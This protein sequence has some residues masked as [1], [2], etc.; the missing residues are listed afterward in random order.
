M[1]NN[2][3]LSGSSPIMKT[4]RG[5]RGSILVFLIVLMVI[6]TALGVGMVSMFGSSILGVFASNSVRRAGYLVESGLRYTISEVRNA[7]AT[8]STPEAALTNV[9]D[10]SVN[11]K[12]FNVFPGVA[13]YRV[14]VYPYWSKTPAGTGVAT[15]VINNATV[16][17]S[18]FPP[19]LPGMPGTSYAIPGVGVG[20]V[21]RLQVGPNN[22]VGISSAPGAT[23]GSK[24][25]T[26]NLASAVTIPSGALAYANLAFP[27]TNTS[28][29]ITKGSAATPLLL[30][31]NAVSAIPQKNGLFIDDTS[32]RWY[33]YQT[34][35]LD[36]SAVPPTVKL[37]NINWGTTSC[38]TTC[39]LACPTACPTATFNPAGI[40]DYYLVF[41]QAARLDATGDVAGGYIQ[42]QK[43][44]DS[45]V[46]LFGL[47][48]TGTMPGPN[49][50]PSSLSA[51][52]SGFTGNLDALDLT[53]S[54]NRVVVQGYI[55]TGGT[56]SYWA[57]FQ[58]LGEAGY[59]FPDPE[60]TS[61]DIGWHVAPIANDISNDLRY[62][63][64]QYHN[65]S[66]DVQIK[67]GWD[68]H[69]DSGGSGLA[70]R[71]HE[72]PLFPGVV[73]PAGDDPYRYYQGYG[74]TF[75]LYKNDSD[76]S[77]DLIP[78]TIKPGGGSLKKKL[79]LVLW[80]QKVNAGGVPR[81]DW[82][83]YAE[84]GDPD[85]THD[86]TTERHPHPDPDQ[87]VTGYQGWPDGRLNDNA[88][89][90]VRVVDKFVT[91]TEG[92]T[93]RYNDIKVFYGDASPNPTFEHDSRTK[94]AVATNK[95]RARYYP[96]WLE[97]G[98]PG[99]Y[100]P[101]INPQWPTNWFDPSGTIAHW[102]NN[103][104]PTG[105]E[106][107]AYDY[108]SLTSSDPTGP[109]DTV[110][111]VKNPSPRTGFESPVNLLPDHCTIRTKD[112]VLDSFPS[113]R[114]EI[115]LVGMGDITGANYTVAFDDF[116][117]QM[118]GGL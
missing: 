83:A 76:G 49:Q 103:P 80:E 57:A 66:Y 67:N 20:G 47:S 85:A 24:A 25:V 97:A 115:G 99:Q 38:G 31:I 11:G 61:R 87:K 101:V 50:I 107:S 13:R 10:G 37:E 106:T 98:N 42:T 113:G 68:L 48:S 8:G 109:Y 55:A 30:N 14:R 60:Q 5:Q 54:G 81:K 94:D 70:F 16:P 56:H 12:W 116:Y 52:E 43:G 105:T 34:A 53:K 91:T 112:F 108:F 32:G 40:S 102:Y 21:A 58:H 74:I 84:L 59:R 77:N 19:D 63:W 65:L 29:T 78:N 82:L 23:A 86:P 18:G 9:D 44:N 2:S 3:R 71:W 45:A 104:P 17:N 88:T 111:W 7:A 72:S 6:F 96:A 27:T 92:V 75:M 41:S 33:T 51:L 110:T 118:L 15:N 89:V 4:G 73:P 26:Y 117:I 62:T 95:Q 35:W 39:S 93:T 1:K 64:M 28:Q 90:I 46:T 22:L 100:L 114:K 36:S 79:L 69:K